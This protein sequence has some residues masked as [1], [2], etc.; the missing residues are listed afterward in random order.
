MDRYLD[1]I[2]T[3]MGTRHFIR[4]IPLVLTSTVYVIDFGISN[5]TS[6]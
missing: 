3:G 4:C 5:D 2:I 6:S 1:F